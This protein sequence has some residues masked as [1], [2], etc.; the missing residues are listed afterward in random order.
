MS[1]KT[2]NIVATTPAAGKDD[3]LDQSDPDL[4]YLM[5]DRNVVN[6]PASQAEWTQKRLVWVP[7]EIAGFVSASIKV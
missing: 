5:V 1:A 3:F 6:D 7:H 4:K 2:A